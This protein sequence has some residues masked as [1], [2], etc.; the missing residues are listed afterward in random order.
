MKYIKNTIFPILL[1]GVAILIILPAGC[2]DRITG[3]SKNVQININASVEGL[4]E[5]SSAVFFEL[6]VTGVSILEPIVQELIQVENHL[7]GT[8]TVPA[9]PDRKFVIIAL[10]QLGDTIYV[11]ETITDIAPNTVID[12][13]INMYPQ[14]PMIK[15][16]PL[17]IQKPMGAIIALKVKVYNLLD[18]NEIEVQIQN[19]SRMTESILYI[20]SDSD[21]VINPRLELFSD[22][23]V[24]YYDDPHLNFRV[25][26]INPDQ[27]FVDDS[28]YAELATV[29]YQTWN[30][31]PILIDT[32]LFTPSINYM[33]DIA[34]DTVTFDQLANEITYAEMFYFKERLIAE[35]KMDG[36]SEDT[37]VVLDNSGN[38]LHGVAFG[39]SMS[40]NNN[41]PV[42]M[43][44]GVDDFIEVPDNELLDLDTAITISFWINPDDLFE[45]GTIISRR[46]ENGAINYE[47]SAEVS[48]GNDFINFYFSYGSTLQ[49]YEVQ[50]S[51]DQFIWWHHIVFSYEYGQPSSALFVMDI[52]KREGNWV[53]G[54]GRE[55]TPEIDAPLFIGRQNTSSNAFF[56]GGIDELTLYNIA[57]DIDVIRQNWLAR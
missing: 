53:I 13:K 9:G 15:L 55:P 54:S 29:Y 41:G 25:N 26:H 21:V 31:N 33:V 5:T 20:R 17:V 56:F 24:V 12:L 36:L 11:G 19:M 43:F 14:I 30:Q 7:I 1:L 22:L 28:G 37:T 8:V 32:F 48:A 10:D 35:W 38:N 57:L 3:E 18:L 45:K 47:L 27:R 52:I 40:E 23:Q 49:T 6:T 4:S 44:D 34:G 42:R 51:H 39:T 2:S 46:F 16:S 50:I